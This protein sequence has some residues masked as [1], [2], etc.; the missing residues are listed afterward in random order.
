MGIE[1]EIETWGEKVFYSIEDLLK[2]IQVA[3]EKM[4]SNK[5]LLK[6]KRREEMV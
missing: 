1:N 5:L 3:K 4:E 2:E 6:E